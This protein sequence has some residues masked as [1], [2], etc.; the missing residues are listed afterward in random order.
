MNQEQDYEIVDKR[1]RIHKTGSA[2]HPATEVD[3]SVA[4]EQI[5]SRVCEMDELRLN[6]GRFNECVDYLVDGQ[7]ADYPVSPGSEVFYCMNHDGDI[8]YTK[9]SSDCINI[10]SFEVAACVDNSR[11][12]NQDAVE[13]LLSCIEFDIFAMIKKI[14][15]K[16]DWNLKLENIHIPIRLIKVFDDDNSDGCYGWAEVGI[17]VIV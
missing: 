7:V 6:L 8:A 14:L 2:E 4:I 1:V 13:R 12:D 16:T 17:A 9:Q 10:P 11:I 15:Q 3:I 5:Q